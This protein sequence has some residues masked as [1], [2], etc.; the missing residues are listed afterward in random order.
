[1]IGFKRGLSPTQA[2]EIGK[3]HKITPSEIS[4]LLPGHYMVKRYNGSG[5]AQWI[6][7]KIAGIN[8]ERRYFLDKYW[9]NTKAEAKKS[10]LNSILVHWIHLAEDFMEEI[11]SFDHINL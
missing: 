3:H 8:E 10:H 5:S 1:M 9:K 11:E 2:L 7:V 6:I 4:S